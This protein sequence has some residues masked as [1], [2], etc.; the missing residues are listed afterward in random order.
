MGLGHEQLDLY[1]LSIGY[2]ARVYGSREEGLDSDPHSDSDLKRKT[3]QPE[4]AG[5]S[6]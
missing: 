5:D 3:S 6:H 1:R 2:V 4:G